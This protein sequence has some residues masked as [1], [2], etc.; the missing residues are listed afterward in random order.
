MKKPLQ[1]YK[2]AEPQ[3]YLK[4]EESREYPQNDFEKTTYLLSQ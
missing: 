2:K 1:Y 3:R 4:E